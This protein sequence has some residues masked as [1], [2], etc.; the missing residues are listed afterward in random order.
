MRTTVAT[1]WKTYGGEFDGSWPSEF[2]VCGWV[3]T[4]RSQK[5]RVFVELVDGSHQGHIQVLMNADSISNIEQCR[6]L[7]TGS[8]LRIKGAL[9]KS[10]AAGQ[11]FEL[12]ATEV[13]IY[14]IADGSFP[15]QKVDS[16]TLEYMRQFPQSRHR[17]A[18]MHAVFAIKSQI[19]KSI[20]NYFS[21]NEFF[22]IDLPILTTNACEGGCAPL[23][24][25][26]LTTTGKVTDIPVESYTR[27]IQT[28]EIDEPP[29]IETIKTDSIDFSKDFFGNEVFLTV[30]N[31][32]HLETAA[33][34]MGSVYT[35]TP[36]TRGEPSQSTRHLAYF[37]MLEWEFCFSDLNQNIGHAEGCIKRCA[38]DV[39]QFCAPELEVLNE[40]SEGK[41]IAKI[42]KISAEPFERISHRDAITLL[43]KHHVETPFV[44]TPVYAN[45]LAGEHERFLVKHFDKPVVVMRYPMN[46]KAFYMPV[47]HTLDAPDGS[48]AIS[49]VDCYDLLMDIGE[50]VGGSQ[51]IWDEKELCDRM[52]AQSINKKHLQWYIDLRR[53]GS[54]PMEELDWEL[55]A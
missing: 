28:R 31:Q 52:D 6:G 9:V 35:I 36:A 25:T 12:V 2:E 42:N 30:S 33:I 47:Y 46:V 4:A 34:G 5:K 15:F 8:S 19:M 49:Y 54:F 11:P 32:L 1:C 45:D 44:E 41:L 17:T 26:A 55:N 37:N 7:T 51:R 23:Q 13:E 43:L 40:V 14:Q 29:T 16:L 21:E 38:N 18:T 39:I 24:V 53:H 20:H 3:K 50:T 22:H 48:G 27:M 10:P